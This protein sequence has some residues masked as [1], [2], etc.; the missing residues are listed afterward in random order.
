[1]HYSH[2]IPYMSALPN[3]LNIKQFENIYTGWR[4]MLSPPVQKSFGK[5]RYYRLRDHGFACDNGA[6][7]YHQRGLPFDEY[8]FMKMLD[9]WGS[10]CDWIV[11]PD[12]VGNWDRTLEIAPKWYSKLKDL[13]HCMIVAQDGCQ[14]NNFQELILQL[15]FLLVEVL[16]LNLI[17]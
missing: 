17:I 12:I 8:A 11:I 7:S 4:W 2:I 9:R 13:N 5:D 10:Y 15:V 14:K 1:M 16:I 6:F 3:R